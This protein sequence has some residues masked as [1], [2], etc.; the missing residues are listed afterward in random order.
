M[1]FLILGKSRFWSLF[2]SSPPLSGCS[3]YDN[4]LKFIDA[5]KLADEATTFGL[6]YKSTLAIPITEQAL[7]A[8][9]QL[10]TGKVTNLC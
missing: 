1:N 3:R 6:E 7:R 4:F 10:A 5:N 2:Q 9:I 8:S